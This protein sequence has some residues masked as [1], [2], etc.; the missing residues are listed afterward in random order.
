MVA[1]GELSDAC[2]RLG[3]RTKS[4]GKNQYRNPE[5]LA[6]REEVLNIDGGRCRC[7]NRSEDDGVVLQVHHLQYHKGTPIWEY[8]LKDCLTLCK[9]CHAK[10]HGLIRPRSGWHLV[11]QEDLEDL[12]GT[13][14]K[15]GTTIRH[16]FRIDHPSWDSMTVGTFCCDDLTGTNEA[17][18]LM[19]QVERRQRFLSSPQWRLQ[20]DGWHIKRSMMRFR[21]SEEDGAFRIYV[22]GY[23]AKSHASLEDAKSKIF[24]II[25]DGT[26]HKVLRERGI[27]LESLSKKSKANSQIVQECETL[28]KLVTN[29]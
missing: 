18:S 16:A 3:S 14:E 23:R 6:F 28:I 8:P 22:Q 21:I 20:P 29:S 10:Q 11:Y 26:A 15:C 5:W 24:E 2:I 7:C 4:K 27:Q 12:I 9:G 1:I 17:S 19:R 13:C 25:E